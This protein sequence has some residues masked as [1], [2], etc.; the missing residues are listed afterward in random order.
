MPLRV[1]GGGSRGDGRGGVVGVGC[2]QGGSDDGF[3]PAV[4]D[5]GDA[6]DK[7]V[8]GQPGTP[9]VGGGD[10]LLADFRRADLEEVDCARRERQSPHV[11]AGARVPRRRQSRR[12]RLPQR[13]RPLAGGVV[14]PVA[15]ADDGTFRGVPARP[16]A[17]LVAQR[18]VGRKRKQRQLPLLDDGKVLGPVPILGALVEPVEVV[19]VRDDALLDPRRAGQLQRLVIQQRLAPQHAAPV[20]LE[21]LQRVI[22]AD[23]RLA[24]R[25][26]K[27]NR[28][29]EVPARVRRPERVH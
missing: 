11:R 14:L 16:A 5:V 24:E 21:R 7:R 15:A 6:A 2:G 4:F 8:G 9:V 18:L 22:L 23:N 27:T 12:Q 20:V 25:V 13:E 28:L 1:G 17:V 29:L 19:L 26:R 3:G 10:E